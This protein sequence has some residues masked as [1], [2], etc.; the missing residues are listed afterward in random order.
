MDCLDCLVFLGFV[1]VGFVVVL[2]RDVLCCFGLV[3]GV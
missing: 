3:W 1:C 2:G